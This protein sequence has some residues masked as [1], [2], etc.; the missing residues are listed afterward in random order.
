LQ[1]HEVIIGQRQQA[2]GKRESSLWRSRLL[3]IGYTKRKAEPKNATG[4]K[5]KPRE[6]TGLF[7]EEGSFL[8]CGS[9]WRHILRMQ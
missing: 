6:I 1:E 9:Q 7:E 3:A 2:T 4:E 5:Q 8:N